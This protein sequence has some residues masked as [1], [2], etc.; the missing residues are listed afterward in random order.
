MKK[1]KDKQKLQEFERMKKQFE[2]ER[3]NAALE[4]KKPEIDG[5]LPKN[6][7]FKRNLGC[8]G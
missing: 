3:E 7:S 6:V 1:A 5:V 4:E 2:A 8:G